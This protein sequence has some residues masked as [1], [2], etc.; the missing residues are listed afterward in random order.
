MKARMMLSVVAMGCALVAL[1]ASAQLG[2]EAHGEQLVV[3]GVTPGAKVAVMA[4]AYQY[5]GVILHAWTPFLYAQDD[6]GDG[7]VSV[8]YGGA[9]PHGAVFAAADIT[10]GSVV[11]ATAEGTQPR[12]ST[13]KSVTLAPLPDSKTQGLE[14]A[15]RFVVM[16]VVRPG[17][18]AWQAVAGDGGRGDADG[19]SN[20]KVL[21]APGSLLRWI[22]ATG[23]PA[24]YLDGDSVVAFETLTRDL[25]TTT[26]GDRGGSA[27]AAV[28]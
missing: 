18:G 12:V 2:A 27:G 13:D 3:D 7:R 16:L 24:E 19:A 21:I 10:A 17:V 25:I 26:L 23:P 4:M 9:I 5:P 8:A 28:K 14:V 1:P 15:G 20:G 11:L 6:D 22:G